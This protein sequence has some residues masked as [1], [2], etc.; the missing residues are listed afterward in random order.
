MI[1]ANPDIVVH[2]GERLLYCA[3]ALAARYVAHGGKAVFAGKPH[4][5]IYSRALEV[6]AEIRRAP[7]VASRVLAIGDGLRTDIVGAAT[8][9]IDSLFVTGGIHRDELVGSDGH[10]DPERYARALESI[11][12]APVGALHGLAW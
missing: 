5:P 3:G 9:G 10:V 2:R 8:Y 6:A 12:R 11:E 1:C 7:V 4:A